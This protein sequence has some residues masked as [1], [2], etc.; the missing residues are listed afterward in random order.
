MSEDYVKA[1]FER[2]TESYLEEIQKAKGATKE[3]IAVLTHS[4]PD[5]KMRLKIYDFHASR[6]TYLEWL[7][8]KI[9]R[10]KMVNIEEWLENITKMRNS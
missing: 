3:S 5:R 1:R 7:E 4:V 8:E 9:K 2:A 10:S 6:L